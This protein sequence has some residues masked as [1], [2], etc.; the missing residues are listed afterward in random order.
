MPNDL[1]IFADRTASTVQGVNECDLNHPLMVES[2][3]KPQAEKAANTD[4][5]K[6]IEDLSS[7][8]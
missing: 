6:T 4:K 1:Q 2:F 7:L 8:G 5:L 3:N